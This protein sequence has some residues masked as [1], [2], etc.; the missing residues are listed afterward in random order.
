M[1]ASPREMRIPTSFCAPEKSARSS[2]EEPSTSMMR[3]PANS[4]MISPAV[5]IGEIPSSM[6][7]PRL[8]A[9]STTRRA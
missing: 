9:A 5:I 8:E 4:C 7:V 2:R 1:H 6:S 3:V